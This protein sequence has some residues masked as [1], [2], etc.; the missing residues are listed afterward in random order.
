MCSADVL[1]SSRD[2]DAA[3]KSKSSRITNDGAQSLAIL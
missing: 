1:R 2:L 3:I